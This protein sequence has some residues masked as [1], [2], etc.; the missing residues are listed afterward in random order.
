MYVLAQKPFEL[1]ISEADSDHDLE[2]RLDPM[3]LKRVSNLNDLLFHGWTLA[4]HLELINR[5]LRALA[6]GRRVK[7]CG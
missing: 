7:R 6:S 5:I 3:L 2:H 1:K 4:D